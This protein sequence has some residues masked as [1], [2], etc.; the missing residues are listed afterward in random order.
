MMKQGMYSETG[1]SKARGQLLCKPSSSKGESSS[2]TTI[3]RNVLA[4][5]VQEGQPEDVQSVDN[6]ITFC[7]PNKVIR[8]ESLSSEGQIDT[9]DELMEVDCDLFIADCRQEAE[10]QRR[11]SMEESK[12][13]EETME[14]YPG[15]KLIREAELV[16]A[17]M[18]SKPN[19]GKCRN[20]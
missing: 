19:Q 11:E 9:S 14:E 13:A 5:Q 20:A 18:Y 17:A 12:P 6:E 8:R 16:R 10:Q 1:Q 2:S 4:K 3:Y 7:S 15:A